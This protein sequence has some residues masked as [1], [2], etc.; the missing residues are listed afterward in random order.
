MIWKEIIIDLEMDGHQGPAIS[1]VIIIIILYF[2]R[3]GIPGPRIFHIF[4][5]LIWRVLFI[6]SLLGFGETSL[7]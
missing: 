5:I 4:N 3:G 1:N 7:N 2:L 6:K